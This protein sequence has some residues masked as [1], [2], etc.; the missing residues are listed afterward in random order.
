MD[1]TQLIAQVQR[2]T[3]MK[4]TTADPVLAVAA[5]NEIVLDQVLEKL[6]RQMKGHADR[7]TVTSAETVKNA[8]A[9]AE[10]LITDAGVWSETRLK[11]AADAA[12]ERVLRDLR[13][14]TAKAEHASHI[15]IKAAWATAGVAGIFTLLV[16]GYL[17]AAVV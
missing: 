15:A 14:E 5:I 2:E 6:D 17:L 3:G 9:V 13:A 11:A 8:K 16:A 4:I 12:A 10:K 1:R 7:I